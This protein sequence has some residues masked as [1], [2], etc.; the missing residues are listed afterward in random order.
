MVNG[1]TLEEELKRI[2]DFFSAL[3]IEEFENMVFDCGVGRITSADM[4]RYVEGPTKQ[5]KNSKIMK[6]CDKEQL[7][8]DVELKDGDAA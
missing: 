8:F 3:S 1:R 4:K 2:N 7:T 6:K 5:Y